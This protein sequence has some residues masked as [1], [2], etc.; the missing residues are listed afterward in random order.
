MAILS[1]I[2][3]P[4]NVLTAT[5][6]QTVTNKT[7]AFSSNT[8]NGALAAANGGTGLTS[9]GTSGNVLTSNGSAW[10]SSTPA[11]G[12]AIGLVRAISINC[13]LP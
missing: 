11:A 6:S 8:F 10:V 5:N 12:T 13:I 1:S 7:I 3:T 2:I 4:S 9:P